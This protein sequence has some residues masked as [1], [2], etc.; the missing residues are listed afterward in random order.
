MVGRAKCRVFARL[1]SSKTFGVMR[2]LYTISTLMCGLLLVGCSSLFSTSTLQPNDLY[3]TDNRSVVAEHLQA[4]EAEEQARQAELEARQA[5]TIASYNNAPSYTSIVA[6][7]YESAYA[8][9]LYGFNSPTYRLPSSYYN[10]LGNSSMLYATA[11]DPAYYN[12][13]VSGDQVWVEPKYITSMF[14]SWGATNITFGIY[15][16]PWNYGWGYNS[17]PF[18]YS[19]WGYPR[20]S[21]YDWNWNICYNPWYYDWYWGYPSYG[22]HHHHYPGYLPPRPPQYRPDV[23]PSIRPDHSRPNHGFVVTGSGASAGPS[24]GNLNGGRS[25]SSSRYTSPTSNRNYGS[26]TVTA[27]TNRGGSIS[28]G[29]N[30]NSSY[31]SSGVSV[32]SSSR[33]TTNSGSNRGTASYSGSYRPSN[34]S[35]TSSSSSSRGG[36]STNRGTSSS[37]SYRGSSSSSRSYTS[38]SS[39]S[40]GSYSSGS[41]SSS[42]RSGG[43]TSSR[44]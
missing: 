20:Y 37:S 38:S 30:S 41:S 27:P 2:I 21:W 9:R 13:M 34:S 8:R 16:S 1:S 18:H 23:R 10:L 3:R 39:S 22:H 42:S 35:V 19:W 32:G 7:T 44:R 36:S 31:Q 28:T 25:S 11:Y 12:I 26:S 40:R 15:A 24:Y 29:V 43:T 17:C 6:D 14:G 33:P 5:A 4:K